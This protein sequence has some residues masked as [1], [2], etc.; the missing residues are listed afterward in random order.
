MSKPTFY[1]TTPIYF[2]N[3]K[4]HI[5]HTY[6]T[7]AADALA[8]YKKARGYDVK[9]LTGTDE[10]GQKI[11]R[12]AS[13]KGCTPKEHV[14]EIVKGV[15][16]L[17]KLM[18]I[19]N[20]IF[21]RTTDDYHVRAVA[22]IFRKL[23]DQGDIYKSTYSGAYCTPCESYFTKLQLVDGN[24][25]DC[26]RPVETLEEESYFFR[27]SKYQDALIK[28]YKDNP[29]FVEP[30]SR[31]NEMMGFMQNGLEDLSVTRTSHKWGVP[32]EFDPGHVVY[33]WIDALS[34]YI[35]ALGYMSDDESEYKKYWPADVH[36]MA[37]EIVRF[38]SIIWPAILMA[39]GEPLP[40]KIFGHGWIV[41]NNAKMSKSI[42]NVV[43]PVVLA[44]RYGADALRYFILRE[45]SFGQDGNFTNEILVN[46]INA[47]LAND[48]GNLL[49]RTVG[50][51]EK[52]FGGVLPAEQTDTPHESEIIAM[53]RETAEAVEKHM[54]A[55][56]PHE[57]LSSIWSFVSRINKYADET[58][59]W[60]LVKD[61]ANH[62]TL[63][64]VLYNMTES[65]RVTSI[66]I[67]PFMPGTSPEIRRQLNMSGIFTWDS[68][69]EFGKLP[70]TVSITKGA[71]LF[72][73]LELKKEL[74]ELT[75]ISG[76]AQKT[77]PEES[78]EITIDEFAKV[79]LKVGVV[80]ACERVKKSDKLLKSQVKVGDETRQILSGIG[81]FYTPEEMVGKK[82]VVVTNLK[83]AKL[84]GQ[85]SQ[86]MLLAASTEG[87]TE[88]TLISLDGDIADGSE[89]R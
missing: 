35:T 80:L 63:A 65:L 48:L 33:V 23:Y 22:K 42:G 81:K 49:S 10:H 27:L 41:F 58:Q 85:M 2:P 83:P 30:V 82:V 70:H 29:E 62:P 13:E 52:Y 21:I 45:F 25:P 76:G 4:F 34:N 19:E 60:V 78:G 11:E 5:G 71:T 67:E 12:V 14:D 69:K 68:A 28:H 26:K 9:F 15:L 56:A 57:A 44:G 73:R 46:R 17:W 84:M 6:T 89:V 86:G 1:L 55:F 77:E 66:L 88:L 79:E 75:G 16:E 43:D 32:V 59:P 64:R 72:P 8:R 74:E 61:Q 51:I 87:D 31:Y 18:N 36:L 54:D 37:K 40:K 47:D 24:C 3:D 39:L 53:A 50:M 38:H 20:D 7:V